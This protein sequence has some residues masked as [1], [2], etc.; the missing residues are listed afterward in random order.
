LVQDGSTPLYFAVRGSHDTIVKALVAAGADTSGP[1]YDACLRGDTPIVKVLLSAPDVN[2]S[3][4]R[5]VR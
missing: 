4:P 5:L 3:V 1:L 2:P